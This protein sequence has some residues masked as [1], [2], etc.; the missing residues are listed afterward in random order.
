MANGFSFEGVLETQL[1][2]KLASDE[3]IITNTLYT[4]P[5]DGIISE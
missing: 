1:C 4:M 3:E 5:S 2:T